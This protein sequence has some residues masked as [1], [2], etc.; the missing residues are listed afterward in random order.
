M[1]RVLKVFLVILLIVT[2][3]EGGYL[4]YVR[5]KK[6]PSPD[7]VQYTP[8]VPSLLPES[9]ME[10][11]IHPEQLESLAR[12]AINKKSNEKYYLYNESS[13]VIT[14]LDLKGKTVGKT[15]FPFGIKYKSGEIDDWWYLSPTLAS[16]IEVQIQE[17]GG[18]ITKKA[19]N[20]D[21]K[22]GDSVRLQEVVDL[23]YGSKEPQHSKAFIITILRD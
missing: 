10:T 3:I 1:Q 5:Q 6:Q 18:T 21:L 19:K 17:N 15:L 4:I 16:L 22:V 13:G 11:A 14:D 7:Q 12:I 20:E 8:Q 2:A 23:Y 9:N